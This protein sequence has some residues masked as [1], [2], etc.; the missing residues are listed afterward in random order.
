LVRVV[1]PT[2]IA[3]EERARGECDMRFDYPRF[4]PVNKSTKKDP[5]GPVPRVFF[6]RVNRNFV[7]CTITPGSARARRAEKF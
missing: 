5:E 7:H 1:P 6:D 3:D 4:G 2:D